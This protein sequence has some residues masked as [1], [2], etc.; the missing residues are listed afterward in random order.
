MLTFV[1]FQHLLFL[2][3]AHNVILYIISGNLTIPKDNVQNNNFPERQNIDIVNL[4]NQVFLQG[5]GQNFKQQGVRI[6]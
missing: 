2:D 4:L 1:L 5:P 3:L 6:S